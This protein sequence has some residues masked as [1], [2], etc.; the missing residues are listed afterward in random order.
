MRGFNIHSA[1]IDPIHVTRKYSWREV[2]TFVWDQFCQQLFTHSW[3]ISVKWNRKLIFSIHS[4]LIAFRSMI[5]FGNIEPKLNYFLDPWHK[6]LIILHLPENFPKSLH[7]QAWD[8]RFS[9]KNREKPYPSH[10]SKMGEMWEG[11]WKVY[12]INF[13]LNTDR[14]CSFFSQNVGFTCLTSAMEFIFYIV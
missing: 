9:W 8:R 1:N 12:F 11:W 14:T 2:Y 10:A 7:L 4:N 5:L 6:T 3:K 13:G